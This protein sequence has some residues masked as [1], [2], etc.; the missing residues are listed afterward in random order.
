MYLECVFVEFIACVEHIATVAAA[1]SVRVGEMHRL[2]MVDRVIT[3]RELFT[4]HVAHVGLAR[5]N[6]DTHIAGEIFAARA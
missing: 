6:N 1:V 3:P 5:V 4:A 2:Q